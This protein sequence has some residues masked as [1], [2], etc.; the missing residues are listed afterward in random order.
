MISNLS[1]E[2]PKMGLKAQFF[3][4]SATVSK[5]QLLLLKQAMAK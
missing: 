5:A 1:T 4:N 2:V 3:T